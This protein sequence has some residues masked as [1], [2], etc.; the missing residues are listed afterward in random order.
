MGILDAPGLSRS[1]ADSRRRHEREAVTYRDIYLGTIAPAEASPAKQF[2]LC[3]RAG[4][5]LWVTECDLIVS[6]AIPSSA[7]DYW[8]FTLQRLRATGGRPPIYSGAFTTTD[9]TLNYST[10]AG[11][12][13]G[14]SFVAGGA[15]PLHYR[16]WRKANATL[17]SDDHLILKIQSFG[18]PPS[19]DRLV[20]TW[21]AVEVA[22]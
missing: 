14:A 9:I 5:T 10:S 12:L 2:R 19:L 13:G 21:G 3:A 17:H 16:A 6:T 4:R 20:V 8:A 15:W 7:T 11:S 22:S 1:Q 18:T